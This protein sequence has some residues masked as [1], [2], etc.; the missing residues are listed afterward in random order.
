MTEPSDEFI[1][2]DIAAMK[3]L[4]R[5]LT[6]DLVR[7]AG[8]LD[9][10]LVSLND[11]TGLPDK[12]MAWIRAGGLATGA[13]PVD[14][15]GRIVVDVVQTTNA[16]GE[17]AHFTTILRKSDERETAP[18]VF[19]S[20]HSPSL[21]IPMRVEVP[22]RAILK[23][24]PPLAGTYTL[25][26]HA[27]MTDRGE[28]YVY[29]GITKRGWSIRFDEHTRAAV[30]HKSRRLLARTLD[31]LIEARAAERAGIVD[32]RPKLA[33]IVSAVCGIGMSREGALESEERLVEK[34]SLSSKHPFGL[35]MIPGGLAGL[36]QARRFFRKASSG[37]AR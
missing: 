1:Y 9:H 32:D 27:L 8:V 36:R 35:N 33:G 6:F 14:P 24:N 17:I 10:A 15:K 22:L 16:R 7:S 26:L 19:F 30:G 5:G 21:D 3:H 12:M 37:D 25:Y 29:Y 4:A 28:E 23:G 20:L 34:Y 13:G 18:V 11:Q 31:A 2:V